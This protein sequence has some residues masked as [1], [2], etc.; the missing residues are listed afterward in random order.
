MKLSSKSLIALIIIP[1]IV[2]AIVP[3]LLHKNSEFSGADGQAEEIISEISPTY[4]SSFEPLTTLPGSETE[5]LLFSLQAALGGSVL[6]YGFGY[7]VAR[8]RHSNNA[9]THKE[10]A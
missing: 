8:K 9:G 1:A 4:V 2:L 3:L 6:G 7:F 10:A 5:S